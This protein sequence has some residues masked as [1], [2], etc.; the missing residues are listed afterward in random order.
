MNTFV[1][2]QLSE[3]F[4]LNTEV[5]LIISYIGFISLFIPTTIQSCIFTMLESMLCFSQ[6]DESRALCF[7]QFGEFTRFSFHKMKG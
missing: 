5:F 2:V 6:F 3:T 4:K 7:S 1:V